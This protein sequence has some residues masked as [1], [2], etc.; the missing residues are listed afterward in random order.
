M[1]RVT[2][3]EVKEIIDVD[4]SL[5]DLSPFI[6]IANLL[7][8]KYIYPEG[9]EADLL[10]EIERWLAAHFVAVRDRQPISQS[11][12]GVSA[13]FGLKLGAGLSATIY[14]QQAKMLD[15]TG[16]LASVDKEEKFEAKLESIVTDYSGGY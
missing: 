12:A 8:T 9:V 10:K 13:D 15:P 14:G 2:A 6:T 5:T 11:V 16:K 4:P 1:A 7:V 3:T